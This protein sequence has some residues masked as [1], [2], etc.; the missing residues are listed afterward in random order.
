MQKVAQLR[1][2]A[3][4]HFALHNDEPLVVVPLDGS[5]LAE[6]IL[7]WVV[8]LAKMMRLEVVL[9]RAYSLPN[10]FYTTDE[11]VPNMWEFAERLKE[12]A[13]TYLESRVESLK[14]QG[15]KHVSSILVEGD[16]A[17][18]IIDFA[19]KTPENLIAMSTHGRSGIRRLLG[20]VTDRVVRNSWDPV[21]VMPP[22]LALVESAGRKLDGAE[23]SMA[24]AGARASNSNLRSSRTG[25]WR[26]GGMKRWRRKLSAHSSSRSKGS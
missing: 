6:K 11:Y 26:A 1:L 21:L 18:E 24:A 9:I 19:R 25:P 3:D 7:P 14:S 16:G 4:R 20:S 17:A 2:T 5:A 10:A 8:A 23:D 15:L 22:A 12:E 13:R